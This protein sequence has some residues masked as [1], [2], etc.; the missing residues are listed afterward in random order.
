MSA[1]HEHED[2]RWDSGATYGERITGQPSVWPTTA[3][4]EELRGEALRRAWL[5]ASYRVQSEPHD[6][7]I[8]AD[9]DHENCAIC[10]KATTGPA[11][12]MNI[13]ALLLS[14]GVGILLW[15][16]IAYVAW[17]TWQAVT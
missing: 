5:D 9:W 6:A 16:L 7:S 2:P 12:G 11:P 3:R 4:K 17:L 8:L 1:Q 10:A 13:S 15:G 14:V